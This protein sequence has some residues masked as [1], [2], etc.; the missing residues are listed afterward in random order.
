MCSHAAVIAHNEDANGTIQ[1]QA[2]AD[3]DPAFSAPLYDVTQ[4]AQPCIT[5]FGDGYFGES[6]DGSPVLDGEN[7]PQPM[8]VFD[9]GGNL[10][11]RYVRFRFVNPTLAGGVIRVGR[12]FVGDGYQPTY[13][14]A[15]DWEI[16]DDDQSEITQTQSS[17]FVTKRAKPR[18]VKLSLP[19]IPEAEA[20]RQV[21]LL[22]RTVG[23]SKDFIMIPFPNGSNLM[24][25]ETSVY[26]MQNEKAGLSNPHFQ[27]Y[28]SSFSV[29]ELVR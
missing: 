16:D 28:S 25:Y 29:R 20:I 13:N 19:F 11:P 7:D 23:Q 26:G 1:V 14:F 6:I 5:D 8:R 4:D 9:F 10:F 22:K 15:Y 2:A 21:R 12:L 17:V 24:Q 27:L 3:G 18:L